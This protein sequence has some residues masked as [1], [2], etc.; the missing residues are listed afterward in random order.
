MKRSSKIALLIVVTVCALLARLYFKAPVQQNVRNSNL[1]TLDAPTDGV[2][3]LYYVFPKD[4]RILAVAKKIRLTE[5][6]GAKYPA[7]I[8]EV[9]ENHLMLE[10]PASE[11]RKDMLGH[12][13]FAVVSKG[14]V[15]VSGADY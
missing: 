13:R 12:G 10:I 3:M 8:D 5:A 9:S 1:I 7:M 2:Y 15:K 14:V 11:V 6:S 4:G